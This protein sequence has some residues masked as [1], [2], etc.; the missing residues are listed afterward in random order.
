MLDVLCNEVPEWTY[1]LDP[2]DM[3]GRC[4]R[5]DV[6]GLTPGLTMPSH[7]PGQQGEIFVNFP[8]VEGKHYTG[9]E[10]SWVVECDDED[11]GSRYVRIYPLF[12]Y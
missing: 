11:M 2:H 5:R 4:S 7:L 8:A 1:M 10:Q 12:R 9:Q 3:C 6:L